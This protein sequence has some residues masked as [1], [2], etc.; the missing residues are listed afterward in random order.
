MKRIGTMLS[1]RFLFAKDL[2]LEQVVVKPLNFVYYVHNYSHEC[3]QR[4]RL[5]LHQT[6]FTPRRRRGPASHAG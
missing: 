6:S 2:I 4:N 3:S 1:P 5:G